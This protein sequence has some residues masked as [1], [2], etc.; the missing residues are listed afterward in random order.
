[1]YA[2]YKPRLKLRTKLMMLTGLLISLVILLVVTL[3]SHNV[4][5]SILAETQKRGVA[6]AQLF[7]A[8][9]LN[10]LKNYYY[11]AIQQNA[12]IAKH[13]NELV[14][15]IVYDKEGLTA[16]H[17]E[18]HS[19]ILRPAV[20]P[21]ALGSIKTKSVLFREIDI[22]KEKSDLKEKVFDISIPVY[23]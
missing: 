23:T 7:G 15:V 20:D 1:M 16:A 19:L 2:S 5:R 10:Y 21:E 4:R 18:N 8:T 13:E 12:H 9:V 22:M 3:V 6:I 14:Y 17:T 11:Q